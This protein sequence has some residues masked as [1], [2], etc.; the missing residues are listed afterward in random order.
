MALHPVEIALKRVDLAVV[1]EHPERLC[2]PPLREGIGGITL[3]INRKGGLKPLVHKIGVEFRH[4]FGQHHA[5]VDD[6]P[7]RERRDVKI[8][9]LRRCSRLFNTAAYDVKLALKGFFV[10]ALDVRDED[11][12]DFGPGRVGL[13]AQHRDVHRHMAPAVDVITHA[14]DFS[15]HDR[16]AGLLCGKIST[17][18]EDLPYGQ[19]QIGFRLMPGAPHLIVEERG[20]DLHVNARTV[21]GLAIGIDRAPMPDRFQ[22]LDAI[23]HN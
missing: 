19:Q 15:F 10:H 5:L 2:Q 21:A 7:A 9:H 14:Q 4:L 11:L 1:R 16:P 17:R 6:R 3:V 22:R 8:M 23:L 13:V 20:R 12:L 18:Q